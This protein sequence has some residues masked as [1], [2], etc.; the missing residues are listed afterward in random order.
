MEKVKKTVGT[1][2]KAPKSRAVLKELK[3]KLLERGLTPADD[4]DKVVNNVCIPRAVRL[5]KKEG[6]R[7]LQKG[8][9]FDKFKMAMSFIEEDMENE[10]PPSM[11]PV[12]NIR[13]A[14][15]K[16]PR[17][18]K[19]QSIYRWQHLPYRSTQWSLLGL[20]HPAEDIYLH[21]MPNVL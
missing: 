6:P 4:L 3:P 20:S 16:R 7:Y 5:I 15:K 12:T 11:P 10:G 1:K 9:R 17:L 14:I 8:A 13:F 2:F 19:M 18:S 21:P